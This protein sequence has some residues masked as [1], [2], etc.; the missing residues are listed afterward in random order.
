M[1]TK[2]SPRLG[3]IWAMSPL[4]VIEGVYRVT[5]NLTAQGALS[6][7][8]VFHIAGTPGTDAE[9]QAALS[10]AWQSN[11]LSPVPD[12]FEPTTYT[13]IPLDGTTPSSDHV[14]N[15]DAHPL[16]N[17]GDDDWSPETAA[18]LKFKSNFR[19]PSG[20]GRIFIGPLGEGSMADGK[21][22]G[23]GVADVLEAWENFN[24]ALNTEAFTMCV[25]S[26]TNE[27]AHVITNISA[28]LEL[29]TQRRRLLATRS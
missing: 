11:M 14:I 6:P 27:V 26:Y 28:N 7:V 16:C 19:G 4:P 13:I 24:D 23:E 1:L 21:W 8:N 18:V 20:R 2:L 9:A 25:A 12:V 15:P 5:I 17:A 3:S 22:V 10:L 29:A